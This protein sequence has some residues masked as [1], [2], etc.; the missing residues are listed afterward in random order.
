MT[1]IKIFSNNNTKEIE[2]DINNWLQENENTISKIIDI[3]FQASEENGQ[4][5]FDVLIIAEVKNDT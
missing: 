2:E 4:H 5:G 3:K 1:R